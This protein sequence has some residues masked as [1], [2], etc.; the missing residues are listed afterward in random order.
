VLFQFFFQV[1]L[2]SNNR[3]KLNFFFFLTE[4]KTDNYLKSVDQSIEIGINFA[5]SCCLIKKLPGV[6][7][8]TFGQNDG[9]AGRS[10]TV[11]IVFVDKENQKE[12]PAPEEE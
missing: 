5:R 1:N 4:S 9:G 3:I 11:R 8:A 7:V 12:V 2:V 10:D 6:V